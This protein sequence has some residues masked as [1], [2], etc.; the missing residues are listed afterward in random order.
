M[1]RTDSP[2]RSGS[3][4]AVGATLWVWVG[5]IALAAGSASADFSYAVYDGSWDLLPDFESLSPVATGQSPTIGLGVT[6]ETDTFGLVFTNTLVAPEEGD[7]EFFTDSDDGSRLYVDG[8]LVVDNDGLHASRTVIGSRTL[9]AGS[10]SLRVEF[11]EKS[12]GQV[13]EVGY[14]TGDPAFQPIP[15]DGELVYLSS[16]PGVN[17][18][19]GPVIPWPEIAISAASL[20]DGRVL[21][22]S[23]TETNAFPSNA[24]FTHASVFDPETETFVSADNDF[25][26]TFC[27]GIAT[28]ENGVIVAAGG[29]P[30][31][32]KVSS[33]DPATL[34]WSRLAD[35]ND[36]RWYGA[37]ATLPNN[38]VFA[39][40]A[41]NSGDRSET[42]DPIAD[43]WTPRPNAS[44]ATL[45]TEQNAINA[46]PNPTGALTQEWW[47]HIAVAPQGDV[48]QG[49]P[50]QTW[51]RF[52]PLGGT[53]NVVLGQPIGDEA[54]MY[55][56][57]IS[58]D[59]GK[60]MLIG[61]ADRRKSP[62]TSVNNVYLV[63]LNGPAPVVTQGAP[64]NFPRALSNSVTL[65]NGE[66]LV[67]GGNTVAKIFSDQGSVL[68]AEIYSPETDSWRIVDSLTIPRNYHSTALLLK[69]ARVLSAGGGAC[70]N[71]C[72]ANHLDGQIYSPPYLFEDDD[73]PAI[74][75]T[76]SIPESAQ[77]RA[78]EELVVE[79]SPGTTSFSI[80]R[81]SGTTHH[82]N[83]DQRFLRVPAVDNGD[84]SFT[85]SMPMNPNVLIVGHYWLFALDADGTPSIGE[86]IQVIRDPE[87]VDDDAVY[88]SDLPWEFEQNGLGPAERDLSNGDADP[89]DGNP[90]RL[91]GVTYEK[92]I[93]VHAYSRIDVRLDGL[94]DRFQSDIGLDD[95]RDGLCGEIHFEVALDGTTLHVSSP[96]V[97][98]T[99]TES[100]DLD[101]A[102]GD[103]LT[104]EVFDEGATCGDH[105]DWAGARLIPTDL[106]GFRFY[107]FTPTLLR[108]GL[109]ASS[110]QL[111]ELSLFSDGIRMHAASVSNPGGNNPAGEGPDRADDAM[112]A[113]KWRDFNR[114]G[115]IYD[116]G[117]NVVI[118]GY[119]LTTADDA[120]ER[121]PIRWRLEA[122]DDGATW[123]VLD[124]RTDADQTVPIERLTETELLPITT[125]SVVTPLPQA[126]R[127]SSTLAVV[128]TPAGD[129][130]WNVNPDHGSVSVSDEA[131]QLLAE[132]AVG[133]RPWALA[134]QPGADRIYVTNKESASVSVIDAST[135]AVD[136]TVALARGAQPHGIVFDATGDHY[137]VALEALARIEKR[138]SLD[139]SL[140]ASLDLSGTP[141]HLAMRFDDSQLLVSN[142]ITPPIPGESTLSVAVD[143]GAAEVFSVDPSTLA[144]DAVLTLPHDPRQQSESQGPGMPNYLGPPVISFD[145]QSAYIPSKKDNVQSGA[146]RQLP[147]MTFES[148]VRA[149]TSRIDL[150]TGLEDP[151]FRVDHDNS[152]LATGAALT[153]DDRYLLVTLE[154]SR[155]LAVYDTQGGFE[156]MRLVT[157]RAPQSVAL[158]TDGRI[159][160]VHNFMDRSLSRF[161]LTE[162]LE[163]NLPATQELPPVPVVGSEALAPDVLLGKQH[164]YDGRDD[165]LALDNYMSCASCHNDGGADG[166]VWDLGAF[167]EGLR[168]TISLRGRGAPGHGVLHWTGNFDEVQDFEGQIRSLGLGLGLMSNEDF[169]ATSE[170]IGPPKAG[171]SADLDALAAYVESLTV[172][173]ESPYRPGAGT[174]SPEA[175]QGRSDFVSQGCLSCHAMPKLTD[176]VLGLR[177]DVGTLDDASGSRLGNPLDGFD[178]PSLLGAWSNPPYLHDGSAPTLAE[179]ILAHDDFASLSVGEAMALE[180]FLREAESGDLVGFV[181]SDGDGTIDAEDPAP[182]DPCLPTAFVPVCS[183]DTD[184]DGIPDYE[185]GLDIDSDGDGIPDYQE[186][187]SLDG[188][189]DG[190]VDQDDPA[191]GDACVPDPGFCA[192]A[193]PTS[194]PI[195]QLL[196]VLTLAAAGVRRLRS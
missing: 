194:L 105:G 189:G 173:L 144:L 192:P 83:T 54:R 102:G 124:D 84:G 39:T 20:P 65:P 43:T 127:S 132:I 66:V 68:P 11:F 138:S 74:R 150:T 69:D 120:P 77:V 171:L 142:F 92:G 67:I 51:H 26:D 35:M 30:S 88:V 25:H 34:G 38:H 113:T 63:D 122:S 180:S 114:G 75:P 182:S 40:F 179:A 13:L 24:E 96:F 16:N 188:D 135:L 118:D 64:M 56:N 18:D 154:T 134:P 27:A 174:L 121:D 57:A 153:G 133:A 148:T 58:Y 4:L 9:S 130:I 103:L 143:Q 158:S 101:V 49:G 181:D 22:W 17:G 116:Y 48:F 71:G 109:T 61:G 117:T 37:T 94:Y 42:Y 104:L 195:G 12:G 152:S 123:E 36:L 95:E 145:E 29:N 46:A 85:L 166:R 136:H 151:G 73:S 140:V 80:V 111:A 47:A 1:R 129:R 185:E 97:D 163:T 19:W 191:N 119:S 78:G 108:D 52:D 156:L 161:D 110:I 15:G 14:R 2:G 87:P 193:V 98:T 99:P 89:G 10:H 176:S 160:Y 7:Y 23:S 178:T 147:G 21:T 60:V 187:A 190:V 183:Q 93:G 28:L 3:R 90:I 72:S 168:R 76:L 107:R 59:E 5:A 196:I 45:V 41:K 139:D 106:P 6:S 172:E 62:P 177:H 126:P 128:P 137:F 170:P 169:G 70:G 157:G 165:R 159:A 31:D 32:R 86:A 33:F 91:D 162:M 184:G 164:F 79:A 55:G 81:L 167:G 131:G 175:D 115:L 125:G 186:S 112:S 50:T 155:E 100:I 8:E 149:N 146:L 141:R 44:M 82:L 53:P